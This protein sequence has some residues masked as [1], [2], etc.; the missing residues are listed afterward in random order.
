MQERLKQRDEK[1]YYLNRKQEL[2]RCLQVMRITDDSFLTIL[3]CIQLY[4]TPRES[5]FGNKIIAQERHICNTSYF[6][7]PISNLNYCYIIY[8]KQVTEAIVTHAG[9]YYIKSFFSF[10]FLF[11]QMSHILR[12]STEHITA[13]L[14]DE[15][16]YA[17][18]QSRGAYNIKHV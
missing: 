12:T 6:E 4:I 7:L 3:H 10:F 15:G 17:Y 18:C 5:Y 9:K 2:R 13:P 16:N 8:L 14:A 11:F 1:G